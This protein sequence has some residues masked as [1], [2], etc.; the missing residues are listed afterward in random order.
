PQRNPNEPPRY[1]FNKDLFFFKNGN[2]EEKSYIL[3]LHKIHD[4]PFPEDDWE[5][6]MKR[7][8]IVTSKN[9][10]PDSFSKADF[11]Y[12]NKNDIEYLY[13]LCRNKKVD[14]PGDRKLPDRSQLNCHSNIDYSLI[15][16]IVDPY[17]IV[18]KPSTGLI[19]LN[20]EIVKFY[21]ATLERVLNEV[22]LK[23]FEAEFLKKTPLLGVLDLNIMKAY[24]REIT[25]RLRHC[26]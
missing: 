23:I 20:V 18:D 5:E 1:L 25:K 19:Y 8:I 15:W 10:K 26:E 12:L 4:V 14:Y 16:R 22:K 11:K 3:S 24:V 6:K 9:D 21:D 17:S 7:W 13:N 2:T